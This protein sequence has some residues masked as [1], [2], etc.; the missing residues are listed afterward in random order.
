MKKKYISPHLDLKTVL[1]YKILIAGGIS[2]LIFLLAPINY[3]DLF[4]LVVSLNLISI[5]LIFLASKNYQEILYFIFFVNTIG[6]IIYLVP[7]IY[8][9][10]EVILAFAI[11]VVGAGII[12]YIFSR[13]FQKLS[14][15]AADIEEK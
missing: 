4:G 7:D 13:M 11:L 5:F 8:D 2:L 3:S 14:D 15:I 10:N 1:L 6:L 12:M 9:K